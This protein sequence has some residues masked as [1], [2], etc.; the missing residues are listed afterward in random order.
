MKNKLIVAFSIF[1]GFFTFISCSPNSEKG[2]V[3]ELSLH[4]YALKK[5]S[6]DLAHKVSIMNLDSVP[7]KL[8][9]KIK[10][11]KSIIDAIH[12]EIRLIDPPIPFPDGPPIGPT[13]NPCPSGNCPGLMGIHS[14]VLPKDLHDFE[15]VIKNSE[16]KIVGGLGEATKFAKNAEFL[17]YPI[18]VK[19]TG[20]LIM[21]IT[22]FSEILNRN[23]SYQVDVHYPKK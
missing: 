14:I 16:G 5:D 13:P 23:I 19:A 7:I 18:E 17:Q 12:N 21:E 20:N 3:Y 4:Q 10:S 2:V 6:I 8:Q 22:K 11:N 9:E 1:M 15:L